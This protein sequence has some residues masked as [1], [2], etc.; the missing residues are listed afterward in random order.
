MSPYHRIHLADQGKAGP[1][2]LRDNTRDAAQGLP[3]LLHPQYPTDTPRRG[4]IFGVLIYHTLFRALPRVLQILGKHVRHRNKR[5]TAPWRTRSINPGRFLEG[6]HS[7]RTGWVLAAVRLERWLYVCGQ[8]D[9]VGFL[10]RM[11]CAMTTKRT[12]TPAKSPFV[13]QGVGLEIFLC[14]RTS[15]SI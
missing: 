7:Q 9:L 8:G 4:K 14:G 13:T 2:K 15:T 11:L 5:E 1:S 6:L 12:F 10:H 3:Y